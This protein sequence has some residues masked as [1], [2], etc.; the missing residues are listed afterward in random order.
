MLGF[1]NMS[2]GLHQLLVLWL[3]L[4]GTVGET[5]LSAQEIS[6]PATSQYLIRS[7]QVDQGIPNNTVNAI[8]QTRDGY[9]WLGTDAGL[10]R[11]DGV[12]SRQFGLT[13][14]LNS[15]Q[16]SALQTDH[17]GAL[18]I[19]TIG[20]GLSRYAQ[21]RIESFTALTGLPGNTI[22]SLAESTNGDLWIGSFTGISRFRAG[23]FE[24]MATNLG[25]IHIYDLA[26]DQQGNVWAA[27]LHHGL[28]CFRGD[29]VSTNARPPKI[30]QFNPRC[31]LTDQSGR[32]WVGVR[33]QC[34]YCLEQGVWKRYGTND[35]LPEMVLNRLT[36]TAEGTVWVGSLNDGLY[37]F[38]NGRFQAL[39]QANGLPDDAILSLWADRQFLWVGSQS[40]GLSRVGPKKIS[41]QHVMEGAS[42]CQLRSLAE[43]PDGTIW[44]GMYGQ[45]IYAG[46]KGNFAAV[47]EKPFR[48]H[49]IVEALLTA[50]DGSLWWGAGPAVYQWNNG[51]QI[52]KYNE[53]WL[54]GDRVWCLATNQAG[55]LWIG[56]Y[57][58][59]LRQLQAGK[60]FTVNGLSGR[61]LTALAQ[62]TDGALW[63]GSL[64]G[65]LTRW[66]Q[67]KLTTFTTKDGLRSNS[68]RALWVD[69]DGTLWIGTDG[70]G[71]ARWSQDRLVIFTTA[72]GLQEDTVLQIL[73]DDDGSLWLGGNHGISRVYKRSLND[74]AEGKISAL[75]T[76]AFSRS[77]GMASE[78][79]VG[80]FGAALKS[81]DGQLYFSTAKGIITIDPRQQTNNVVPPAVLLEN[82]LVDGLPVTGPKTSGHAASEA[83]ALEI[84]PGRHRF[85]F[86]YTGLSFEAPEKIRFQYQLAGLDLRSIDA[87]NVRVAHYGYV[88]PGEYRFKVTACNGN[89]LW[90][91]TG[92]EIAFTIRPYRWQTLWFK[93][94]TAAVLVGLLG[95]IIRYAERRRYRARLRR[96]EQER[97]MTSERERIARD[98]HDELGSS[99]NFIAMSL[100]DLG[101]AQGATVKHWRTRLEKV[102]K[103]AIRTACSLDEIVWA[104]NPR[105]DTLRSLVEY[106]TQ[107]TRELFEDSSIRCRFHIPDQLPEWPLPPEMRH[108]L[109]LTV[110]EALSNAAKHSQATE[111]SLAV[112]TVG[113]HVKILIRD[114]GLGFEAASAEAGERNGLKNMR[115]RIEALGGQFNVDTAPGQGT[116][117]TLSVACPAAKNLEKIP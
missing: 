56:T 35:G 18:W 15:L 72:Q 60:F 109:F 93:W 2:T 54:A 85:E 79:C 44:A 108:N 40:G 28:L 12:Q 112:R 103:Y 114:D 36:Q 50:A 14:G 43:T 69:A 55:G 102:S 107:I 74:V 39:R 116:I 30:E 80:N 101:R 42:E 81:S 22:S 98:L 84:Q 8:H 94:V 95:L 61:P 64:G 115:Q 53:G 68:I 13:E 91:P 71:L 99:L 113:S 106:L 20:G 104:V 16:V 7:W 67:G 46:R 29:A 5:S 59:Q 3:I 45:A 70:G 75:H 77:D 73:E 86:H 97:A 24:R 100:S 37:Y 57:N 92:A 110:R 48:D 51:K 90:H 10:I 62:T 41:V 89:G 26:S 58:G 111:I 9:L 21:G 11:F 25:S 38:H 65:G 23:H 82:I 49:L 117:I 83:P 88:P 27:T 19:G 34:I 33:E 52:F 1:F 32:L 17:Q 63:I 66:Q 78:A 4:G 31:V 76:L 105:N 6:P 47:N 87:G 96:L